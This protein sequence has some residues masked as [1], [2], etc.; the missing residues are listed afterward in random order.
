MRSRIMEMMGR[1]E[2]FMDG[3]GADLGYHLPSIGIRVIEE[4][5]ISIPSSFQRG[6]ARGF[7]ASFKYLSMPKV[8]GILEYTNAMPEY[9]RSWEEI[10]QR[11]LPH[12]MLINKPRF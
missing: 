9:D 5:I 8:L 6:L 11:C 7:A 1:N 4:A 12:L 3:L 2:D 10:L